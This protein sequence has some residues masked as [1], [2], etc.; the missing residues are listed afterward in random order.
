MSQKQVV[1]TPIETK[2]NTQ[3]IEAMGLITQDSFIPGSVIFVE[4][5]PEAAE[6]LSIE[7]A[8]N[9]F[10]SLHDIL[11]AIFSVPLN[12]N[13]SDAPAT[14]DVEDSIDDQGEDID[15]DAQNEDSENQD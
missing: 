8:P 14:D 5:S 15:A 13:V 11:N 7:R 10:A 3:H 9:G 4:I 2:S 1:I 6:A 12:L